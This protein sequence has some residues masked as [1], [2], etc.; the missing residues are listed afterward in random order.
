MNIREK[1]RMKIEIVEYLKW[2]LF[3]AID[4]FSFTSF[5]SQI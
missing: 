2:K 1:E 4:P 3:D 5:L